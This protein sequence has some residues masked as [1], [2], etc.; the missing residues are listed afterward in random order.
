MLLFTSSGGAMW[1]ISMSSINAVNE[2][3]DVVTHNSCFYVDAI[4]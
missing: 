2:N 3:L 4:K 1:L